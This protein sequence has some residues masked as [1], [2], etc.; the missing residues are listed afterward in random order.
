[1]SDLNRV[2]LSGR[3]GTDVEIKNT[4]TGDKVASFRI[5]T[6]EKWKDKNTGER[7]EKTEW[8]SIVAFGG[9]ATLAEKVLRKGLRAFIEGPLRTRKWTDQQGNDRF[10]TE[11]VLSGFGCRID[12]IDWPDSG[13]RSDRDR[14]GSDDNHNAS[15][16][17]YDDEIPF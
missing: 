7:K 2:S 6:G 12:P 5:A 1:M 8:H 11:I 16:R 4:Q 17:D 3:L 14:D 9:Y 15:H 13:G 10:S